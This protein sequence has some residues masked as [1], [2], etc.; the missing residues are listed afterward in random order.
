MFKGGAKAGSS[1]RVLLTSVTR[2]K[3][4]LKGHHYSSL[5][6]P[7]EVNLTPIITHTLSTQFHSITSHSSYRRYRNL[8]M[9]FS[10]TDEHWLN[11]DGY[12]AENTP[13]ADHGHLESSFLAIIQVEFDFTSVFAPSI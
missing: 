8:S 7:E 9:R 1:V 2:E 6:S 4:R 12:E 3:Q 13:G 11:M 5:P 10:Y